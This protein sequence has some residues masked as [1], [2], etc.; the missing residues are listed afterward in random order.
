ML[1]SRVVKLAKVIEAL[2]LSEGDVSFEYDGEQYGPSK[3]TITLPFG[4]YKRTQ[5]RK[6]S[7]FFQKNQGLR[8]VYMGGMNFV[9][10]RSGATVPEDKGFFEYR[11]F[12]LDLDSHSAEV[13]IRM[14]EADKEDLLRFRNRT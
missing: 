10:E 7:E 6:A 11:P 14:Y 13:L 12:T 1:L 3:V 4:R 8:T 2:G 5:L 9:R